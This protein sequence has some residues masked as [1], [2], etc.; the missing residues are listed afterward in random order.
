MV[1]KY[2]KLSEIG[3]GKFLSLTLSNRQLESLSC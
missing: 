3:K 1:E 2:E